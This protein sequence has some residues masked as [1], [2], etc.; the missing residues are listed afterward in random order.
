MTK[1]RS[2]APVCYAPPRPGDFCCVPISGEIGFGVEIGQWLDRDR[3]QP[4]DHA[5]FYVGMPDA[6]GAHG[7]TIGAYPGGARR[8]PLPCPAAQL[9]GS[10]WSS[11]LIE[12][13]AAQRAG[14][15]AW[16]HAHVGTPYSF[17]DY[18]ALTLHGLRVPAPGLRAYIASTAHEICSQLIDSGEAA[19]G[20]RLFRDG[21][22]PGYVKPGDLAM[23]LQSLAPQT[24]S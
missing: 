16:A 20:V 24:A 9:P 19:N 18:L 1:L 15:V 2:L 6:A 23:L 21:R 3:F 8:L 17:L 7:Y 4:Y 12:P 10:L 22:W 11:G 5:E 13:T 14:I